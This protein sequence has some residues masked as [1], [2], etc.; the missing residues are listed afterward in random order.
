MT[1]VLKQVVPF[2]R[3]L[4]EYVKMFNLTGADR[5][6]RILGVG[7]GPASFNAEMTRRGKSVISVDPIYQFSGLE[8]LERFNQVLEDIIQ[9]V[10]NT[11]DDWVWSYH[12]SPEDLKWNRVK[13]IHTF[14]ED[15]EIGKKAGR[16]QIGELPKMEFSNQ[17]F[18]LALCSHFLFLYADQ[19]DQQFH[20][21][22]ITEMLR[23]SQEV[24]LFPLIT[25][26]L[27]RPPFLDSLINHFKAQNYRVDV[28]TVD[29]EL[30]K[31]G[32]QMLVIRHL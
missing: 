29:Y 17:Q 7:D 18:D 32:N 5:D 3:S 13:V 20:Q 11:P 6:R 2:G 27:E 12:K 21:D 26:M 15:Y 8:I 31:G 24:R 14:V 10:R 1:M 25:L 4:N 23:V 19:F 22:S 16:Y 28:V 9:Q 30:Q